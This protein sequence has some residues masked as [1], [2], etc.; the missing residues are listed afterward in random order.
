MNKTEPHI[1][2]RTYSTY[3]RPQRRVSI[4]K[5]MQFSLLEK[6]SEDLFGSENSWLVRPDQLFASVVSFYFPTENRVNGNRSH[7]QCMRSVWMRPFRASAQ[8]NQWKAGYCWVTLNLTLTLQLQGLCGLLLKS[9]CRLQLVTE[10]C[11]FGTSFSGRDW[12]ITRLS[13]IY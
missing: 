7:I 9:Q 4:L 6:W 3:S 13:W 2:G 1:C 5:H 11:Y 12:A 10:C 8:I